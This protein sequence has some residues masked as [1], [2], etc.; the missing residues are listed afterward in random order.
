[1]A[2]PVR[3]ELTLERGITPTE[4]QCWMYVKLGTHTLFSELVYDNDIAPGESNIMH[5]FCDRLK[6]VLEDE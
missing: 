3:V 1:M 2:D 4:G 5:L 6:R